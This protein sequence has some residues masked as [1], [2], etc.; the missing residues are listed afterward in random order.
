M[1]GTRCTWDVCGNPDGKPAIVVHGGPG[2]AADHLGN[3]AEE[4]HIIDALNRFASSSR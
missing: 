3:E 2:S 4:N 1:T